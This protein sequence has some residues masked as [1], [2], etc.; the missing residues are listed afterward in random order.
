MKEQQK[1]I[2]THIQA[3]EAKI[4]WLYIHDIFSLG[5]DRHDRVLQ[6]ALKES[7][8]LE[9]PHIAQQPPLLRGS[10]PTDGGLSLI[11]NIRTPSDQVAPSQQAGGATPV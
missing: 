1:W 3:I 6:R 8:L 2:K 5:H 9:K 11:Q 4:F 10:K 7:M